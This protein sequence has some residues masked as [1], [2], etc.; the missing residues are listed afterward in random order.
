MKLSTK[1]RYAARAMLELA[2]RH[3]KGPILLKDIAKIQGVS[4]RYLERIM[5][6]LV[7]A[8]LARS[9]RGHKGGFTLAKNPEEINLLQIIQAV[10]GSIALVECVDSPAYCERSASC[11][12]HEIWAGLKISMTG[13][14]EAVTLGKMVELQLKKSSA[15]AGYHI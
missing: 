3:G 10:E 2:L 8:G 12:A 6:V 7:S 9:Y 5:S 11:V 4:T 14:L 1:G 13:V 15:A